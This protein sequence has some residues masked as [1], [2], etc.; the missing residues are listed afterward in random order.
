MFAIVRVVI[1]G[2]VLVGVLFVA[3]VGALWW[4]QRALIYPRPALHPMPIQRGQVV[5]VD[6]SAERRPEGVPAV[7]VACWFPPSSPDAW[8]LAFWHGNADQLGNVGDAVG[9]ALHSQFGVGFLAIEYPGYALMKGEPNEASINWTARRMVEH[10]VSTR[11]LGV[12]CDRVCAFGQ[13]IGTAVALNVAR[14]VNLCAKCVLLSPF[15]SIPDMCRTFFS[16]VP[17]P[18]L[19]VLDKFDSRTVAAS[20]SAPVLV[21]HGTHDEIVPFE[22]GSELARLLPRS[23]FVPLPRA[24]HNNTFDRPN[25]RIFTNELLAF[26]AQDHTHYPN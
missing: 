5:E 14:D 20:V 17:K 13:S 3:L 6:V 23:K 4:F 16:F 7:L 22:Q 2:G 21:L 12:R 19:F 10:L 26:L 8:T 18:E 11:G 1:G 9:D 24:G 15:T 25:Y